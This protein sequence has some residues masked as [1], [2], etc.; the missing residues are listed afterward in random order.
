MSGRVISGAAAVERLRLAWSQVARAQ[1][2]A[3]DEDRD[4]DAILLGE[5]LGML[6]ER[7]APLPQDPPEPWHRIEARLGE[8]VTLP[9]LALA[10]GARV[11][12]LPVSGHPDRVWLEVGPVSD[13]EVPCPAVHYSGAPCTSGVAGH[14][15]VELEGERYDHADP[16]RGVWWSGATGDGSDDPKGTAT[17]PAPAVESTATALAL[18]LAET[19]GR[20][21]A[22]NLAAQMIENHCEWL[23]GRVSAS[24]RERDAQAA[25]QNYLSAAGAATRAD[26]RGEALQA[27]RELLSQVSA[28]EGDGG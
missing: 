6:G 21:A 15:P 9:A 13:A 11:T 17:F 5:V 23:A 22:F 10:P 12:C 4:H 2:L 14:P 25:R 18:T 28:L 24:H 27:A 16:E 19:K 1:R 7:P 20:Q 8:W 3:V 26:A